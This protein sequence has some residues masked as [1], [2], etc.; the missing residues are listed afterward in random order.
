MALAAPWREAVTY[1]DSWPHEYVV[2]KKDG[3]EDLLASFC[4]RMARG[5]GVECQ[6][7]GQKRKYLFLGEHKYCHD[8]VF[9]NRPGS[10]RRC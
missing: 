2:V 9:R 5:E 3:Q 6:F 8:R 1:R 4:E 10:G 7:F